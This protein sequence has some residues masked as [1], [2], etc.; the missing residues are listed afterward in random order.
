[1]LTACLWG[2]S[3]ILGSCTSQNDEPALSEGTGTLTLGITTSTAF[4]KAVDES[5]YED[6]NLYTVQIINA[7][8]TTEK[9]FL[10]GER[11]ERIE[12]KNGAY[13][14][15]AFYGTDE[16]ASRDGFYVEGIQTFNVE[17]KEVEVEVTCK[18]TCGKVT[19]K[20][21]EDMATYFSDYSVSYET[22]ALAATQTPVQWN[23]SDSEPWYLKLNPN[24]ETVKAT[25]QVTRIS[26]N[27]TATVERTYYMEPEKS[28]TLN[29][30]P[31]NDSGNLGITIT[32]DEN[33][34]DET[35][36][37]TVPSDWI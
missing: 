13:T 9:D 10:Y 15:K 3:S 16:N 30:A 23:K 17:G 19:A 24:G 1:M 18:P 29:I 20:F 2:I 12:L 27:K 7:S 4:T 31:S 28:W 6:L 25:I 36:D 37:I 8:G 21:A 33:T 35:I 26:D 32:V 11:P 14:L 5:R 22:E 34:N